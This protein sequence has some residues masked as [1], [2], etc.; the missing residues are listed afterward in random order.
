MILYNLTAIDYGNVT[1]LFNRY[2][3]FIDSFT[4]YVPYYLDFISSKI[5]QIPGYDVLERVHEFAYVLLVNWENLLIH[6]ESY[7]SKLIVGLYLITDK[8]H[9]IFFKNLIQLLFPYQFDIIDLDVL[10]IREFNQ[11]ITGVDLI[12]TN[13]FTLKLEYPKIICVS[14]FPTNQ[15]LM[16][17]KDY[18]ANWLTQQLVDAV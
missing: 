16:V 2:K 10:P 7:K 8:P 12:I 9:N 3:F 13:D 14:S 5:G 18:Y 1:I 4:Q 17:I 11:T 15:Q 6:L